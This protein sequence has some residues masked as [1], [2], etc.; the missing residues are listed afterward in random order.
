MMLLASFMH[1]MKLSTYWNILKGVT[2]GELT[3][4]SPLHKREAGIG[5]SHKLPQVSTTHGNIP[6]QEKPLLEWLRCHEK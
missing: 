4:N 3:V 5:A 6:G 1:S 2:K